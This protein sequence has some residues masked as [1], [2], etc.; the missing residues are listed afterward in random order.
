MNNN[1]ERGGTSRVN[2]RE[3]NTNNTTVRTRNGNNNQS[4]NAI[5]YG[6]QNTSIKNVFK[7]RGQKSTQQGQLNKY[8]NLLRIN[9]SSY[10]NCNANEIKNRI[11]DI[12]SFFY[13]KKQ[14]GKDSIYSE[15]SNTIKNKMNSRVIIL[16]KKLV[17]CKIKEFKNSNGTKSLELNGRTIKPDFLQTIGFNP[18]PYFNNAKRNNKQRKDNSVKQFKNTVNQK[19][20]NIKNSS[21]NNEEKIKKLDQLKNSCPRYNKDCLANFR[22]KIDAAKKEIDSKGA[23]ESKVIEFLKNLEISNNDI[24]NIQRDV[25]SSNGKMP[26]IYEKY[27]FHFI[28]KYFRN[29]N[30]NNK[31]KNILKSILKNKYSPY[32]QVKLKVSELNQKINNI[33]ILYN[34]LKNNSLTKKV[35][36]NLNNN[37]KTNILK[38]N[39]YNNIKSKLYEYSKNK[40]GEIKLNKNVVNKRINKTKRMLNRRQVDIGNSNSNSNNNYS[41]PFAKKFIIILQKILNSNNNKRKE[42]ISKYQRYLTNDQTFK[43]LSSNNKAKELLKQIKK[44]LKLSYNLSNKKSIEI[45]LSSATESIKHVKNYKVV[46]NNI[47]IN[48]N[49][50]NKIILTKAKI[51]NIREKLKENPTNNKLKKNINKLQS[52]VTN[53]EKKLYKK[54]KIQM[55]LEEYKEFILQIFKDMMHDELFFKKT[56][57]TKNI[58]EA[59]NKFKYDAL[60]ILVNTI[61]EESTDTLDINYSSGLN[62]NKV[63]LNSKQYVINY[64]KSKGAPIIPR[65]KSNGGQTFHGGQHIFTTLTGTRPLYVS[66]DA[67]EDKY[68]SSILNSK[69]YFKILKTPASLF[70]PGEKKLANSLLQRAANIQGI[71]PLITNKIHLDTKPLNLTIYGG[72]KFKTKF[73]LVYDT[74]KT[75]GKM[76][77]EINDTQIPL[78]ITKKQAQNSSSIKDKLG[79]T[80]GDLLQILH[81]IKLRDLRT[82]IAF[83]THDMSAA[84]MYLF[85]DQIYS[86]QKQ[87][88]Q[89]KEINS[90][91]KLKNNNKKGFLNYIKRQYRPKLI[92]LELVGA[93]SSFT[94]SG[95]IHMINLNEYT[96]KLMRLNN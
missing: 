93:S 17:E 35:F 63:N 80:S 22:I 69:P 7:T 41:E 52:I 79:K 66:I 54:I 50:R 14:G 29:I 68:I 19:I 46:N 67:D 34:K 1:N 36:N 32:K 53:D 95:K 26:T 64:S 12:K 42:I 58:E 20:R 84:K 76:R 6:L 5:T 56:N 70:D 16:L 18:I 48:K 83:A 44:S 21:N 47:S 74:N 96:H 85:L 38:L 23:I 33:I 51:E 59:F 87:E 30:M 55:T 9:N 4:M 43:V 31:D 60:P 75:G 49:V 3:P 91:R 65:I 45:L 61:D 92:F 2:S 8:N 81:V 10:S 24:K 40:L 94:R 77:Y 13:T 82:N 72:D 28:D 86:S 71:Y 37:Q 73:S 57:Q 11:L 90:L 39:S 89:L 78:N 25:I 15:Q 27:I 62:K 88:K